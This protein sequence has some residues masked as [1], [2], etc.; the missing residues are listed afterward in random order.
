[1]ELSNSS[2]V[3][4]VPAKRKHPRRGVA[5]TLIELLVVIAIISLLAALL[6]PVLTRAKASAYSTACKS[7][8]HQ[9]GL[10]VRLYLDGNDT[11]R[12]PPGSVNYLANGSNQLI[13]DACIFEY[14]ANG[15]GVFKCPA[16]NQSNFVWKVGVTFNN[17]YGYN[18]IGTGDPDVEHPI[19]LGL[20]G[21]RQG[22][23]GKLTQFSPMPESRVLVPSDMIAI[24]DLVDTPTDGD[25]AGALRDVD[26][27]VGNRHLGGGNVVFCDG[28]VEWGLQTNWMVPTPGARQRW[29]NDHQP[30]PETWY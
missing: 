13:W 11:P 29:N 17:N 15:V 26:D 24:G 12:Y 18:M 10:A 20:D 3:V 30:H 4:G 27:Y 28:H 16:A 6:L 1:M 21:D 25:I 8:L 2:R 14:C 19:C 5:F 7:N 23:F 9:I 22:D